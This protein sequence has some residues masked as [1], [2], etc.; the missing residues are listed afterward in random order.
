MGRTSAIA[1]GSIP[2][3]AARYMSRRSSTATSTASTSHRR[4]GSKRTRS[5]TSDTGDRMAWSERKLTDG[6]GVELSGQRID[7]TLPQT[8]RDAVYAA[9]MRYGVVVIPGQ[10]LSDDALHDFAGTLGRVFAAPRVEGVPA[11]KILP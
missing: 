1:A 10:S 11:T 3:P 5:L 2:R 7:E 6:F 4:A 8:E 9:A